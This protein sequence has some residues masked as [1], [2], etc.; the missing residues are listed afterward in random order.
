MH[1]PGSVAGGSRGE[2]QAE[3]S[4]GKSSLSAVVCGGD[5]GERAM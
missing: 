1:N 4:G 2:L 3:E 5:G